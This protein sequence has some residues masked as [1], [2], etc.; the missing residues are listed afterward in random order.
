MIIQKLLL[1]LIPALNEYPCSPTAE[2]SIKLLPYKTSHL[3]VPMPSWWGKKSQLNSPEGNTLRTCT[4][5]FNTVPFS[6]DCTKI[7]TSSGHWSLKPF[8]FV[9]H[10]PWESPTH[11]CALSYL[12]TK[13][14]FTFYF[15]SQVSSLPHYFTYHKLSIS[16]CDKSSIKRTIIRGNIRSC[17]APEYSPRYHQC[18]IHS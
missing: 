16:Q 13:K 10:L 15:S 17:D 2:H 9:S 11:K 14:N 3:P 12:A 7:T 4:I 1:I 6:F 5:L 8:A 18:Y